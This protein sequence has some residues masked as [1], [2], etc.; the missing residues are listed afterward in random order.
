MG[1]TR[2][3]AGDGQE[4]GHGE[5]APEEHQRQPAAEAWSEGRKGRRAAPLGGQ[6]AAPLPGGAAGDAAGFSEGVRA[7][8]S[9]AASADSH[10]VA[11]HAGPGAPGRRPARSKGSGHIPGAS[12]GRRSSGRPGS[13]GR[14]CLPRLLHLDQ[15][16][17]AGVLAHAVR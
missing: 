3:G 16:A 6:V 14:D 8:L 13:R 11:P 12:R 9:P 10:E 5:Q 1:A 7:G 4:Q 2:R 15:V 17:A